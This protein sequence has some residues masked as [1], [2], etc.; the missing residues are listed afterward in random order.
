[1][2]VKSPFCNRYKAYKFIAALSILGGNEIVEIVL[3]KGEEKTSKCF[4]K[5]SK[6]FWKND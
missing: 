1:M 4:S 2:T 3:S 5:T 6:S